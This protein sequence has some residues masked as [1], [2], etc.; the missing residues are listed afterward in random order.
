MQLAEG[1]RCLVIASGDVVRHEIVFD[2]A[3]LFVFDKAFPQ[4][5]LFCCF[6]LK[7]FFSVVYSTT[8][9]TTTRWTRQIRCTSNG[10][11]CSWITSNWKRLY[12][13]YS[14]LKFFSH[15]TSRIVFT[16]L[17][18]SLPVRWKALLDRDR[19]SRDTCRKVIAR[20]TV[21]WL[22]SPIGANNF[23]E[24][25]TWCPLTERRDASASIIKFTCN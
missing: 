2:V 23:L 22:F 20:T 13:T 6:F 11:A 3:R 19:F 16:I 17:H 10:L 25:S 21:Y 14:L 18:H 8:K 12:Y 7:R 24:L 15:N 9:Y 4:M 5:V 1:L